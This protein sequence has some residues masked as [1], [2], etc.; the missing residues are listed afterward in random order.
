VITVALLHLIIGQ[1]LLMLPVIRAVRCVIVC[2]HHLRTSFGRGLRFLDKFPA[3]C[4]VAWVGLGLRCWLSLHLSCC[5]HGNTLVSD[6]QLVS[7]STKGFRY[8][9]L[10]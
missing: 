4:H 7:V 10:P 9:G 2:G 1:G 5:S 8:Y 6:V 3:S